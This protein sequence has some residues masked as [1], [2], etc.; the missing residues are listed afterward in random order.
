MK[1]KFSLLPILKIREY[2][3]Y[4]ELQNFARVAQ[5]DTKLASESHA[6]DAVIHD[7]VIRMTQGVD[8]ENFHT[9]RDT[10]RFLA[11]CEVRKHDIALQREKLKPDVDKARAQ[12]ARVHKDAE[13]LRIARDTYDNAY[14]AS[15]MKKFFEELQE[16]QLC[17]K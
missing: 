2:R 12:Y 14:R 11:S 5:Q 3:E 10:H 6:I 1:K 4:M 9:M 8:T 7:V 16:R 17:R 15:L 13:V